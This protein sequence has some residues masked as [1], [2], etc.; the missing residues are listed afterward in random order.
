MIALS[1]LANIEKAK[2]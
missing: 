2:Q 1:A